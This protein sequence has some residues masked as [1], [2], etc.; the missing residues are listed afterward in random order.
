[1]KK[2]IEPNIFK[3]NDRVHI[4]NLKFV[5]YKDHEQLGKAKSLNFA[6][7]LQK[8]KNPQKYIYET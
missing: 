6:E 5:T 4:R 1:M 2:Q 7:N 8:K 3:N